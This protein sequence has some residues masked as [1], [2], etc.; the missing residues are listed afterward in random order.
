MLK[1]AVCITPPAAPA[2]HEYGHRRLEPVLHG[3]AADITSKEITAQ[4]QMIGRD[5][6]IERCLR[7]EVDIP[8]MGYRALA[9]QPRADQQLHRCAPTL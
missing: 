4:C 2:H 9:V 6:V 1:S 5:I 7:A 8:G 3:I